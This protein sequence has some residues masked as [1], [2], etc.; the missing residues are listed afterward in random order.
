MMKK[1]F[2][3]IYVNA[4]TDAEITDKTDKK[5]LKYKDIKISRLFK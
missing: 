1:L 2:W 4:V 3:K 5:Q